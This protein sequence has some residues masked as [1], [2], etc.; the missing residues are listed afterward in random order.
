MATNPAAIRT[1]IVENMTNEEFLLRHA[2]PGCVGLSGG[3]TLVDQAIRRAERHLDERARWGNWSHAFIFEGVRLDARH[4]VIESDLQFL[5]K[6]IQ[7]GVQENRVDKYFDANL[8][9]T[10]AVLDFGL[11]DEQAGRVVREGLEMVAGRMRYSLREL[12][13]TLVALRHQ[14]LRGR[15]NVMSRERSL[16]CSAFVQHIFRKAGIDLV[17]GVDDKN[18]T[19]EDI[20]RSSVPHTLFVLKRASARTKL[21]ELER[22]ARV[23]VKAR[24]RWL[25]NKKISG[26]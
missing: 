17:P 2:Q 4:W 7:L 23:G 5:S 11:N 16:Y 12:V 21:E 18:T 24:L 19:P 15:G 3:V 10:L 14:G 25:K 26:D 13:G 1:V 22:R 6:H 9:T 8:Y 20:S